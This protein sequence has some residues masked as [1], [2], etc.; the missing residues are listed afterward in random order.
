MSSFIAAL[1]QHL[2]EADWP[3]VVSA[4]RNQPLVW[5]QLQSTDFS[6]Q[7]FLAAGAER[8]H[9]SPA[10]LGL[11]ALGAAQQFENLRETPM[12]PVSEKLRYDAA[13]AYEQLAKSAD[14]SHSAPDLTQAALL[15]LALRER[16]RLLNGWDQLAD[17]L[18]VASIDFW[19]LP[20]ACLL[21]LLPNQHDLLQYLLSPDQPEM[22]HTLALHAL[23][24]NPLTLDVQSAHLSE[25]IAEYQ[26]PGLLKLLR[27]L[28]PLHGALAQHLA[29]QVLEELQNVPVDARDS[30]SEIQSLLLQAEIYQ[31]GGQTDRGAALLQSAWQATQQ[32]QLEL[33][34]KVADA[35]GEEMPVLVAVQQTAELANP[36]NL[37]AGKVATKR[38]AALLSAARVALE[39]QDRAEAKELAIAAL[40]YTKTN[41]KTEEGYEK[42]KLLRDLGSIFVE[43]DLPQEA[44]SAAKAAIDLQANDADSAAV[45]GRM[46]MEK[47]E[48]GEALEHAQLASALAPQRTDLRRDLAI[49]LAANQQFEEAYIEWKAAIGYSQQPTTQDWLAFASAAFA[50]G[51]SDETIRACRELLI[52]DPA[53]GE[54]YALM[55]KAVAFQGDEISAIDYLRRASELTPANVDNWLTLA[56]LLRDHQRGDEALSALQSAQKYCPPSAKVQA[57]MATIYRSQDRAPEAL[58]SYR[59]ATNLA[60]EQSDGETAQV[61]ALQL[62]AL[63]SEM[64]ETVAARNTLE[65]AQKSFP[66][67]M[68]IA[69]QFGKLLL[70]TGES[71]RALNS[72]SAA[73]QSSPDDLDLLLDIAKAQLALPDHQTEAELTLQSILARND[74][75]SEASALLADA[76]FSVGKHTEAIKQY[77]KALKSDLAKDPNWQKKLVLGKATSQ[78]ACGRP[79]AAIATLEA[80]EMQH[81]DDLD[82]L[83]ALCAAYKRAGRTEEAA[84]L[85]E[86]SLKAATDEH[87]LLWYAETMHE[88]GKSAEACKAISSAAKGSSESPQVQLALAKL[89]WDGESKKASLSA[90]LKLSDTADAQ[91]LREAGG[92][93]FTHKAAAESIEYY[94][95]AVELSQPDADLLAELIQAYIASE[96]YEKALE[97]LEQSIQLAPHKPQQFEIKADLLQR[98]GKPQAALQALAAAIEL[99]PNDVSIL[100]RKTNLLRESGDW[101]AALATADQAFGIDPTD[102]GIV[103]SAAELA[104]LCLQPERARDFIARAKLSG[105]ATPDLMCLQAELALDAGNEIEA[106]KLV[107]QIIEKNDKH[108]RVVAL[109]SQLAACRGDNAQA[110]QLLQSALASKQAS[111]PFTTLSIG[112]SAERVADWQTGIRLYE[113]MAKGQPGIPAAH[114]ALGRALVLRAEWQRLCEASGAATDKVA[115]AKETRA[116][117]KKA[118]TAAASIAGD[119]GVQ[120]LIAGWLTRAELRLGSINTEDLG[121]GFPSNAGEAA[122]LFAFD[123]TSESRI[124][125]F[126]ETPEVLIERGM[127]NKENA[128]ELFARATKQLPNSAPVHALAAQAAHAAGDLKAA[129]P[130]IR[131]AL[132]ISPSQPRWQ[133]FAGE[134]QLALGALP[135]AAQ[136]LQLAIDLDPQEAK[137]QFALGQTLIAAKDF[138]AAAPSLQKAADLQPHNAEYLLAL[139]EAHRQLGD[140]TQAKALAAKASKAAPQNAAASLMQAELALEN[141]DAAAAQAYIEQALIQSPKDARTLTLF[142]E[143]LHAQGRTEDAIAVLDRARETADDEVPVLIRKAE[144]Q[145]DSRRLDSLVKLSQKHP[146]RPEIFIALSE[147]LAQGGAIVEAIQAAQHAAK[148]AGT[149]AGEQQAKLHLHLGL[150]L[151]QNGNLDQSLHHLDEAARLDPRSAIAHMER[152]R[153]FLARRQQAQALA[154]FRQAAAIAP[155]LAEPYYE[156]GLALKAAKDYASAEV[157]LRQA[158]RL[159]PKD[160]DIQK[161]LAAVI[162]LNLVHHPAPV[163]VEQ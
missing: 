149:L 156:T 64:G 147:A 40:N 32:L 127:A 10:H 112:A 133:A 3:V 85:A 153:V 92:F 151:K 41:A 108:P 68:H 113:A 84:L 5:Q 157:E 76:L 79:V 46:L 100:T 86:K 106:A 102:P 125:K 135:E 30:V 82:V 114:F 21:G 144:M 29:A 141:R 80:I 101:A 36:R 132:A 77:D 93:L 12:K 35:T 136:H 90:F 55:G 110:S 54:A 4:L 61:V 71:K 2:P 18:S 60:A 1:K 162:A 123:A 58:A 57:L 33:G 11:F 23:V 145:T 75:P 121:Q 148:K 50:S 154:A 51:H 67:N 62:S 146:E 115:S 87:S 47:G 16:R 119:S 140:A 9:W 43:L 117:A 42:A 27:K 20:V 130:S 69:R 39:S 6:S 137:Y 14:Q 142:A 56:T 120:A 139:A 7:V 97:A 129:L 24:S 99:L 128:Y 118:F 49:A 152:G 8:A 13:A 109:Q 105:S 48:A 104:I 17:D 159:A 44:E 138:S 72:L 91:T 158:A 116:A 83:R 22:L 111:D 131:R 88:L 150:L 134:I 45:L 89:K 95:R 81:A 160:R 26:L 59:Y 31:L 74:A 96:E 98:T 163:G 107:A 37:S 70:A 53:N 126:W 19:K 38:P 15:A 155:H 34:A 94:E 25:I 103:Q 63:Q 161:Q 52:E 143:V 122:A 28:A 65:A 78:A 73:R 66:G 124:S